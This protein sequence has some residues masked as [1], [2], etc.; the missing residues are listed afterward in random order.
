MG[1]R[2][3]DCA[4]EFF[5]SNEIMQT[6]FHDAVFRGNAVFKRAI[7]ACAV[8]LASWARRYGSNVSR[9]TV[10]IFFWQ[11]LKVAAVF[12][13]TRNLETASIAVYTTIRNIIHL[14]IL[15]LWVRKTRSG[16]GALHQQPPSAVLQ[17]KW[18]HA[19]PLQYFYG[20]WE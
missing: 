5:A 20:W 1:K 16:E 12:V 15:L 6:Y 18:G 7:P 14:Y 2:Q 10:F 13:F 3:K 11:K 17:K 4:R 8:V 9:F 19:K